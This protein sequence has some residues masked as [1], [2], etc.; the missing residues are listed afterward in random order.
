MHVLYVY[1]QRVHIPLVGFE[2]VGQSAH[3]STWLG[4]AEVGF[5][6]SSFFWGYMLTQLPGAALIQS[7]YLG[8]RLIGPGQ[9]RPRSSLVVVSPVWFAFWMC[10]HRD[11]RM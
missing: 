5:A 6:S 7:M 1:T 2:R 3:S 11:L 4:E 8:D 9:S 10:G